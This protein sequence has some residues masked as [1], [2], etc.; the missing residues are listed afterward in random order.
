MR[1]NPLT[2]PRAKSYYHANREKCI[3][4][5]RAWKGINAE[6]VKEA[7]RAYYL[8]NLESIRAHKREYWQRRMDAGVGPVNVFK[9]KAWRKANPD[10]AKGY[11][12]RRRAKMQ[13][14][15]IS[16][17]DYS[18]L[19]AMYGMVCQLCKGD[20]L[21]KEFSWDHIVPLAQGGCH[22]PE[23]LWPAHRRCNSKK[24]AKVWR[25]II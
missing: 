7:R 20:I 14:C 18:E 1:L 10:K 4:R 24:G 3:A 2:K 25:G 13:G 12:H 5:N 17:V 15:E 21:P 23:N 9:V 11:G 22:S 6:A 8:K 19:L 16:K